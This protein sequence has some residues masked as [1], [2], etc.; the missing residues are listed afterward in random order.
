MPSHLQGQ[1]PA[2]TTGSVVSS[3]NATNVSA[4]AT[5]VNTGI[6]S[7]VPTTSNEKPITPTNNS[8]NTPPPSVLPPNG[9]SENNPMNTLDEQTASSGD[10]IN[11]DRS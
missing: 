6:T 10:L 8:T 2:T 9:S 3:S 11:K 4:A 1:Q 7:I 5:G